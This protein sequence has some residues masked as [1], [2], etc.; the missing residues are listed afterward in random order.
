MVYTAKHYLRGLLRI[1]MGWIFLW[2]FL[3]KL[4]GLGFATEAGKSWLDGTSPTTGFL[5]FG[6]SGPLSTFFQ[7]LASNM[8]VDWL[9]M[10]G[11]LLIG[12]A[13]ILGIAMR[14]AC[15]SGALLM[16]LMYVAILL[17]E[18]NPIIDE[19]IIYLLVLL[20][21][22]KTKAGYPLGLGGW[23]SNLNLVQKAKWLQ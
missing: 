10:L 18:H 15:W 23:W 3:D 5:K 19:H 9:F 8:L 2:A 16:L 11:L 22:L 4:F 13:L 6:T 14:L 12:L 21:L 7:S 20:L 17:P 1:T